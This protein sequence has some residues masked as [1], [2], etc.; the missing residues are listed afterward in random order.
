MNLLSLLRRITWADTLHLACLLVSLGLMIWW[1]SVGPEAA[2][3]Y[4]VPLK[5]VQ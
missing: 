3:C 5:E 4:G 1:F 2:R